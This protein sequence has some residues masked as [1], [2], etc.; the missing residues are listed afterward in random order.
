MEPGSTKL[1]WCL[2]E[3]DTMAEVGSQGSIYS[4]AGNL[5]R[6]L[7][8][9]YDGGGFVVMF[10]INIDIYAW[11]S[12]SALSGEE[13]K[14]W[15]D[16]RKCELCNF[17]IYTK[18]DKDCYMYWTLTELHAKV[19][20]GDAGYREAC[21][22]QVKL[23]LIGEVFCWLMNRF[24]GEELEARIDFGPQGAVNINDG[25]ARYHH[26]TRE[27]A[28]W[29]RQGNT[30]DKVET[31]DRE[32]PN[33]IKYMVVDVETHDWDDKKFMG[34][35]VEIAWMLCDEE[36]KQLESR[37]YLVK[38]YG[39]TEISSKARECHGITTKCASELGSDAHFVFNELVNI[40]GRIP[41]DGFVIAHNMVHED[42]AFRYN[43]GR[44]QLD[45]WD[46]APKS[47]TMSIHLLNYNPRFKGQQRERFVGVK[48]S[49]LYQSISSTPK[50]LS[51]HFASD[52]VRMTWEIFQ[53]YK[54]CATHEELRWRQT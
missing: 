46:R 51:A 13:K 53:Y 22:V 6:Y 1:A 40:L 35:I 25:L 34:R 54:E 52:D 32:I 42:K 7:K 47:D 11:F 28:A 30:W 5:V 29:L 4:M 43:L 36:E 17:H 10:E 23:M 12:N 48:L 50:N 49:K 15:T 39:Y 8:Q 3:N 31:L 37:Q 45:V 2:Y 16:V 44:E 38:P 14:M 20:P 33:K 27:R 24:R 9:V 18:I 26:K 21:A 19:Y 41:K